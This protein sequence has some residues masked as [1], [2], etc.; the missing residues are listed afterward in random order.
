[1][2]GGHFDYRQSSIRD[3][4]D[5]VEK[6]VAKNGK[7]KTPRE[8]KKESWYGRDSDW[9]ERYPEDLCHYK[10]SDE[11][12]DRMK[13]GIRQLRLA[14]IY[15]QRI[16]WLLSGDDGEESFVY[17]LKEEINNMPYDGE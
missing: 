8:L 15:A 1:M 10:Y 5:E 12:I 3:I 6:I 11:V 4:A 13:Y 16:D 14:Y 17:R 2:S 9:Y 7:P